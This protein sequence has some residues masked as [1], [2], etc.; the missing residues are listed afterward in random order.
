MKIMLIGPGSSPIP[1]IGWGAIESLVWDYYEN[2]R[3]YGIDVHIINNSNLNQVIVEC[4]QSN[5]DVIHIMYDDYH[6]IAPYLICEKILYTSH[7]A[8]ITHPRFPTEYSYYFRHIFMKMIENQQYITSIYAISPEIEK[9]YKMHGYKGSIRTIYNGA[10]E[11][12]FRFTNEPLYSHKSVYIAK[13]E[14]RKGQYL[15]QSIP[16]IDFVGNYHDSP[17]NKTSSNYLGEWTKTT[18]YDRLTDYGNLIL[19]SKGEADPLVVKEGLIAGLGVVISECSSANLDISLPFIT[20][21]PNDK[22]DNLNY[23]EEKINENRMISLS[24][25]KEIREYAL[26]RFSWK[27]IIR[28]YL[29]L[30]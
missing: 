15:Y 4:N 12:K 11:D 2:L 29:E 26:S 3:F 19:L 30:I 7:Y 10:R 9:I 14:Y 27:N 22:L 6:V 28:Q 5:A 24:M 8:Y 13:I 25:R 16:S 18:L 1:P 17:F 20:V 23:I 21:I